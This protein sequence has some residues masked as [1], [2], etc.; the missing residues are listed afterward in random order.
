MKNKLQIIFS[1]S[2]LVMFNSFA[3]NVNDLA[4]V[5][6]TDINSS[7]EF[8]YEDGTVQ[9][10]IDYS[11]PEKE[12]K[13]PAEIFINIPESKKVA[14]GYNPASKFFDLSDWSLSVPTDEDGNGRADHIKERKLSSGY[15]SDFFY[16]NND[17]GMVFT[18]PIGGF[19]T[20]PNTTYTRVELREMLR[21]GDVDID[22]KGPT[23]NN[24]VHKSSRA[25]KKAGGYDGELKAT[26]A[27]NKVTTTGKKGQIGRVVIG[28]IHAKHNEP[29]RLY[30]RK[31]AD[32]AK[33][34]IYFAHE[35]SDGKEEYHELI[36]TK[37]NSAKDPEGGIALNEKFS[38]SITL[39]KN[40]LTVKIYRQYKPVI[41]KVV[42]IRT[43]GYKVRD[44]YL[45]FKAGVY[46]QNKSGDPKD[47]VQATFYELDNGHK[48]KAKL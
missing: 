16:A 41:K 33:G 42:N 5:E 34:S 32:N 25:S 45:F 4:S 43:S 44:E 1:T 37:S 14:E 46:N 9:G 17:G 36:G 20:S 27:V 10:K 39:L 23:K 47:Y 26:L 30:Y 8:E 35:R 24:W 11:E 48:S 40:E 15:I 6:K 13:K 22:T 18:C 29:M 7:V 2:L 19:K 31:L 21:A 38:Y 3:Q 28:Q 12:K